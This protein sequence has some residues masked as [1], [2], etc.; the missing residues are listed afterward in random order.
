MLAVRPLYRA[1][2]LASA[3]LLLSCKDTPTGDETR[4]PAALD[5]VSGDEQQ[6]AVGSELANPL[7]VRVKDATGLPVIGQLVNFRVTSGGGSVFAGSGLTNAQGIVQDRWTLGTSTA[8]LQRVEAR[9]VDPNTGAAIVFATFRAT[10]LPGPSHSV[11]KAGGDTQTG[12]LGAA[13]GDSL[14]VRVAD[15]FG[16]PVPGV[17]VTWAASAANGAVSPASST[18]SAMG[19]AKTRWTLGPRLDI[20]HQVTAQVAALA[21]AHFTATATLPASARIVPVVGQGTAATVGVALADSIAV[22]VELASGQVVSGATVT[23]AVTGGGGSISPATSTTLADGVARARFTLG[24]VVGAHSVTASVPGLTSATV[25][26][27]GTPDVPATL[28]KT[29]GD[30]QTGVVAEPLPQPV[31]LRVADRYGNAVPNVAVTWTP[32]LGTVAPAAATTDATGQASATWTLG[33][34]SGPHALSAIVSGLAPAQFAATARAGPVTSIVVT[35][36]GGQSATAGSALPSLVEVHATDRFGNSGVG[37]AITFSA[38]DGG[39]FA[40]ASATTD[41]AGRAAS[42]WTLG[43]I[44]GTQTATMSAGGVS[45]TTTATAMTGT[46]ALLAIVSGNAQSGIAGDPLAN[47]LVVRVTDATSNPIAG[48]TVGWAVGSSCGSIS[49]ASTTT[50][51][52][53]VAQVSWTLGLSGRSCIEGVTASIAGGGSAQF[54]ARFLGRTPQVIDPGNF[55]EQ[56]GTIDAPV[57]LTATVTDNAENPVPGVTVGWSRTEGN[58]S[59]ASSTSTT[60]SSGRASVTFTPGTVAGNNRVLASVTGITDAEYLVWTRALAAERV[61]IAGGN[62]QTGEPGQSLPQPIRVRVEDRYGN[63]VYDEAVTFAVRAGGGHVERTTLRTDPS[64]I[65]ATVWVPGGAGAQEARA[66]WG[67]TH[68]T[69]TATGVDGTR[70]GLLIVDGNEQTV[71]IHM[72]TECPCQ[73]VTVR[74][75]NGRGEP[76]SGVAVTWLTDISQTV[77]SDAAGL[78]TLTNVRLYLMG[79]GVRTL[80]ATLPNGTAARFAVIV[81]SSGGG[82]FAAPSH[83][84]PSTARVGRRLSGR[85]LV[86]CS[87]RLGAAASCSI[88]TRDATFSGSGGQLIPAPG[89]FPAGRYEFF[90][91]MPNIPGTYYVEA[92]APLPN[93][94]SATAVP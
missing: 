44:A 67:V 58:G 63:G 26:V 45:A 38:S 93:A 19:I 3:V 70:E 90:W 80:T 88:R 5:I 15:S 1:S 65:A 64:G 22:R 42:R 16:N 9:A 43:G 76:V 33:Q 85:V 52:S 72:Q 12:A 66:T 31:G 62:N 89:I 94:I 82:T 87:D 11:T 59:L 18:T 29:A 84:G 24:T 53:G 4:V 73:P 60:D 46:A 51:A 83:T 54:T 34:S 17:Q 61:V 7:V 74:V 68:V 41:A 8:E 21:A 35:A 57:T 37:A 39:S 14:A 27:T 28:T 55:V 69:F 49:S 40:P 20:P 25:T 56:V 92:A 36:G 32:S 50:D 79:A 47:P 77:F 2:I 30:G 86:V 75:V 81:Q 91:I 10:A 71:T 48:V 6:G 78:A 23:W 13:L